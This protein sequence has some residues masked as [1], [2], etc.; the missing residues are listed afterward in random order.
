MINDSKFPD[1]SSGCFLIENKKGASHNFHVT[2]LYLIILSSVLVAL[3]DY[4]YLLRTIFFEFLHSLQVEIYASFTGA[5]SNL[6][7]FT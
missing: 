7:S 1:L 2:L 3:Q 6:L 4:C 5:A